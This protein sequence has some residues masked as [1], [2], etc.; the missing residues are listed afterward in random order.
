MMVISNYPS[1]LQ[2][3]APE[4]ESHVSNIEHISI[5]KTVPINDK[6][7]PTV[8]NKAPV[9]GLFM[10]NLSTYIRIYYYVYHVILCS[11]YLH[12]CLF[13]SS[14]HGDLSGEIENCKLYT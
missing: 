2:Y 5:V 7:A 3:I 10:L 9:H 4:I 12:S 11:K 6:L 1:H 8:S 13:V 14:L